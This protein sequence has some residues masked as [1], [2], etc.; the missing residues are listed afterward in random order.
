MDLL[1]D[2]L[3]VS[4]ARGSLG[5]RVEAGETWGLWL[6]T[7]PGV[8]LHVV[9]AGTLWLTVPG[10]RPRRMEAGDAVLLP[11]GTEHGLASEPGVM[12]GPCDRERA[13]RARVVGGVVQLGAPPT[14]TTLMT[15]HY[16]QDPEISTPVITALEGSV[17]VAASER[18]YLDDTVR[19][20]T[21][22]L[23]HP[24]IGTTA[25]VN[26]LIDL[27]LLQ[28]VRAWLTTQPARP[29]TS[30]LGALRDPV[31][32]D[33]LECIH[34]EPDRAWTTATLAAAIRVS[35]ATL[36]RRFPAA[37]G[38][39]PGAYLTAWRI[40][41]AVARLRDTD[42]TVEAVAAAVGYT[43][44]HAF[45]RAFRRAHGLTPSEFRT[46]VRTAAHI[47]RRLPT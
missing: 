9:T 1:A 19:L 17:H 20:L 18:A 33:A 27:L 41:L 38:Q 26:S 29:P 45:S 10:T 12:M 13:D 14:Q 32:R 6:D 23:A 30:W 31:V 25:A 24:Q 34:R 4:G 28:F 11:A 3:R 43:S 2:A 44:P 39:T 16:E 5:T 47:G 15:L 37:L 36:S 7:F 42:D 35:R 40:D 8:A 21:R 46:D 22:E